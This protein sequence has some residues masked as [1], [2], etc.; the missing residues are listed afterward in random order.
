MSVQDARPASPLSQR[1]GTIPSLDGIRAIAVGI[2]FFAHSGLEH[3]VPGGLGVTVFFV[4]SG[5]LITTLMRIEHDK[6]GRLDFRGFYLRRVL[7]LAPPLLVI[8]ALAALASSI[9]VVAGEF[10]TGGVLAVLFYLGNYFVIANDFSGVPAGLGIVWSLAVEEHYYLFYPPLAALLLRIGRAGLS[11]GTLL[12]LCA[13]VLAWRC[14]LSAQGVSESYIGMATDTRIDAILAGCIMAL[15]FNPWLDPVPARSARRDWMLCGACIAVLLASLLYREPWFRDT[16]RYTVQSA[17]IAPL[18]HLAVARAEHWPFRWLN[19]RALVWV[20]TVSYTI[21][22]AHHLVLFALRDHLPQAGWPVTTALGLAITLLICELMR[23]FVDRPFARLRRRLHRAPP[24][25][26]VAAARPAPAATVKPLRTPEV[27]VCIATYR[28]ADRLD[29]L[30]GDLVQQ[31]FRPLEVIV[32]DNDESASARSVVE[33]WRARAPFPIVYDVQPVKNISLTRN[34]SVEFARGEWI[35]FVDDDERAPA[36]WLDTLIDRALRDRADGV[37]GP[38]QPVVPADAPAWIR[39]GRFY[40]WARMPSGTEVPSNQLRF[41]NLVL[42]GSWLRRGVPPF[43]PGY[44]LTGGEDGDLLAR[45]KQDGACI[46][47]CD[48]AQV[49]EPI[50]PSRLQLRWLLRRSLRG[51]QDFARH[52]LAGRYGEVSGS[53]RLRLFARALLQAALAAAL[54]LLYWPLSRHRAVL[55][56]TKMYANFGKLSVFWGQH[57]QEYA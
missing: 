22:L 54:C 42:R 6:L 23:R 3:L 34:R 47:W 51:G 25:A 31:K 24:P 13:L 57:Y 46:L 15:L 50:E 20:G 4:L 33:R 11:A 18:I 40:D 9:G 30:L 45:L 8:V 37:L 48:E 16:L 21:Y 41:G 17:A 55:W 10:S 32:V 36:K 19:A 28:R 56:A 7:R 26:A 12:A 52:T 35:A 1:S 2:V 14:W 49:F 53:V 27:S 44:G 39:K 5:F 29:L 38:V 43:D